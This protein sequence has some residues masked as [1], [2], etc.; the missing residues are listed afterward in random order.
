[1]RPIL[2]GKTAGGTR[3]IGYTASTLA[4]ATRLWDRALPIGGTPAITYLADIRGIDTVMVVSV[5]TRRPASDAN[6]T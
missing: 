5:W 6:R 4:L 3:F 2:I 1:L